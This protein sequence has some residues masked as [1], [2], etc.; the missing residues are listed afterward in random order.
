MRRFIRRQDAHYLCTQIRQA[1]R[2]LV[3]AKTSVDVSRHSFKPQH[4]C[5]LFFSAPAARRGIKQC[6]GGSADPG[7]SRQGSKGSFLGSGG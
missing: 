2:Q 1:S 4:P 3:G 7:R 5:F 6:A